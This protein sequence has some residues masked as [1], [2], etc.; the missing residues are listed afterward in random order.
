MRRYGRKTGRTKNN[1]TKED[2]EAQETDWKEKPSSS[3]CKAGDE[4]TSLSLG[5]SRANGPEGENK[6]QT[7]RQANKDENYNCLLV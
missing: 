7:E 6:E 3:D 4:L 1:G 2:R 5:P